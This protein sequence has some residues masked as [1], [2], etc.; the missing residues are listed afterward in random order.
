[1]SARQRDVISSLL[2]VRI[3]VNTD[4]AVWIFICC[5][6]EVRYRNL[7]P[8]INKFI[9]SFNVHGSLH[10]DNIENLDAFLTAS[11]LFKRLRKNSNH[12]HSLCPQTDVGYANAPKCMTVIVKHIYI[13]L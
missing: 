6:V 11:V 8:N 5:Q 7:E 10:V 1:M 2:P 3:T 12:T 13:I 9:L 4:R